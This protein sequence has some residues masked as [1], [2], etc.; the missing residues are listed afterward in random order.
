[1]LHRHLNQ[2]R[3]TLAAID[4]VILRGQWKDW[5]GLRRAVL[6]DRSLLDKVESVCRPYVSDLYDGVCKL[7]TS[8]CSN[9]TDSDTTIG[10][11]FRA[12]PSRSFAT[13][14]HWAKSVG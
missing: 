14:T 10:P 1:M 12:K 2:Q 7:P 3:Y 13:R 9:N 5:A 11:A 4:D 8:H 6:M